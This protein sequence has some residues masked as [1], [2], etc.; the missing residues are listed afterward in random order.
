MGSKFETFINPVKAIGNTVDAVEEGN[1]QGALFNP[2]GSLGV[3][4]SELA[5]RAA[6]PLD[7]LGQKGE[8]AAREAEA[9]Q[10]A[11][12]NEAISEERRGRLE[13]QQFLSPFSMGDRATELSGFLA[14][15]E[16]QFEF[17]QNNPLFQAS[18]DN[19]NENTAFSAA[20]GGRLSSGDTLTALRDNTL[21]AAQPLV[22]AQR[23]DINN[24]LNLGTGIA[25]TQAN[26]SIGEASNVGN[27]LT[28]I[29]NAQSASIAA[30]RQSQQQG[31]ET[32]ASIF[33]S[34]FGLSDSR[35]KDNAEIIG[36]ENGHNVWRWEWNKEASEMFGLEGESR[37]AMVHEVLE[38]DPEAVSYI[39]GY[40]R[41][42][43]A[44][45]GVQNGA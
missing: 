29:G 12:A 9:A 10:I 38:K 18:L 8:E 26:V 5:Q 37:G 14:N 36:K 35:L 1:I 28:D 19:L 44:R 16:A 24:L 4:D 43:Y 40:G 42:D 45:I 21:L 6:D 11:A 17:L 32:A 23:Q 15:P 41:I 25:Q 34:I 20:S 22:N 31:A 7:L 13:G 33:G 2:S 39:D 30:Q 27:L 3:A